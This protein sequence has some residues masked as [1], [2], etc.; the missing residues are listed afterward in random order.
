M[1]DADR[2]RAGIYTRI[3]LAAIGDTTKTGDQ[4]RICRE[5]AAR[6]GWDVTEVYCDHSKSAW[7]KNRKRKQ[8]DR[9]LADVERGRINAIVVYHGDRLVRRPQDLSKLLDLADNK[10]V[11]LASPTGTYDLDKNRLELW[12][13]AAFAEEESQRTSERRQDQYKRWRREGRVRTGGRGGRAY[14]FA[15]DGLALVPAE[16]TVIQEAAQRVLAGEPTLAIARDL[17]AR[18]HRT[19]AGGPFTHGTLRK[20]LGRARYAGLMPDGVSPAAWQPVLDQATWEAVRG[21]LEAKAAGFGYATNARRWLL[22]GIARCGAPGCGA[23]LAIKTENRAGKTPGYRCI[24]P[25]CRRVQRSAEHLDEYVITRTI[26]RLGNPANPPGHVPENHMLARELRT[27]IIQRASTEERIRDPSR[28][29][30]LDMLLSRID[31]I[32]ARL[33]QLRELAAGN[34]QAKLLGAHAAITR[35]EFDGLPLAT[36]RALVAACF[37][38]TVLPASRRGPGFRTEDVRLT[39]A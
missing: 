20:M 23:P 34:A 26:A 13:R 9:M 12:I 16:V 6:L 38:V 5:L 8:W 2:P 14:G 35:E 24:Q 31:W 27:L 3:S 30:Q 7:Q 39:P 28:G 11:K 29:G 33:A 19:P 1:K 32:D 37:T 18:G 10:G 36:R 22:S 4:E 17:T 25:G 21:A 15:K